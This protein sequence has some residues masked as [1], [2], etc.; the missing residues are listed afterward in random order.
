MK[1]DNQQ[2]ACFLTRKGE[3]MPRKPSPKGGSPSKPKES[4]G[5]TQETTQALGS[6]A[7]KPPAD[8]GK[9]PPQ[10]GKTRGSRRA[11]ASPLD[12]S[13]LARKRVRKMIKILDE[14]AANKEG[15]A[16]AR[17][18]AAKELLNLAK[19]NPDDLRG[20]PDKELYAVVRAMAKMEG[21]KFEKELLAEVKK[22]EAAS[23]QGGCPPGGL[24]GTAPAPSG[25]PVGF[26]GRIL[27]K[28]EVEA[29]EKRERN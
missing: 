16:A 14:I 1:P 26:S 28:E 20:L 17:V 3:M 7:A 15:P 21:K 13:V 24:E 2:L 12:I 23:P 25:R 11:P 10:G 18:S 9:A 29:L 19:M 8:A 4:R 27:S 5:T 6:G 22:Q